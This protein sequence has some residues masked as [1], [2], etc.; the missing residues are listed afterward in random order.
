MLPELGLACATLHGA[1][2]AFNTARL[3]HFTCP[4]Y[5]TSTASVIGTAL[6]VNKQAITMSMVYVANAAKDMDA[7]QQE[8]QA[9]NKQKRRKQR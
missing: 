3:C 9:S 8:A 5:S 7:Q 1:M 4:P 2:I 6:G